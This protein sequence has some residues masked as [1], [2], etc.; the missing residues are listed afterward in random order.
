MMDRF[1]L[2]G[3]INA[4][5]YRARISDDRV[6]GINEGRAYALHLLATLLMGFANEFDFLESSNW[7]MT[8][9]DM[10]QHIYN[11]EPFLR[12][13]PPAQDFRSWLPRDPAAPYD[14]TARGSTKPLAR[15]VFGVSVGYH[16]TLA[17]EPL[18]FWYDYL[19]DMRL[20]VDVQ[21]WRPSLLSILFRSFPRCMI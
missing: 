1:C 20:E 21:V 11:P 7:P 13:I 2:F 3:Y 5:A 16:T 4:A 12:E 17:L 8:Y 10:L 6:P 18:F 19:T 15:P 14:R 9:E